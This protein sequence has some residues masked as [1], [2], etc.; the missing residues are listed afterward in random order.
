VSVAATTKLAGSIR[1]GIVPWGQDERNDDPIL[2]LQVD[3]MADLENTDL[4]MN[5]S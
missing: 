2:Q 1:I 4:I 3:A 5:G